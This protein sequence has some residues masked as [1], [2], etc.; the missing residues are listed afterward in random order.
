MLISRRV[1]LRSSPALLAAGPLAPLAVRAQG[2]PILIGG[3]ANDSGGSIFYA[4][5]L[6]MFEKAGLNVKVETLA[7]AGT[8]ASAV[9]GGSLTVSTLT[10]PGIAIA[11]E[12]G[13]PV[14]IIAPASIYNSANPTSGII[15]LKTSPI[16]KA[17]DLNGKTIATRDLS[18][19]SYYG[20][21]TWMDKNGGDSKTV[22]WV[23]I[24]DPATVPAMQSGRVDAASVSEPALDAAIHGP[25]A[26]MLAP[27]YDAIGSGFMIAAYFVT[28]EYART[29]VDIVRKISEV[30]I[31]AGIWANKN[32]PLSAKILEK[33][34][35]VPVPPGTTRVTYAER[36]R[37]A[38]A[39][40]VLDLLQGYGVLKGTMRASDMF[41]PQVPTS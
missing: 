14:T 24:P 36:M 32:R 34:S 25:D 1:W 37:P 40:P 12:K 31:N 5:D 10:I 23:E 2:A 13:I 30:I 22:K 9:V 26:R 38:D 19:M 3:T 41:A 8:A 11:R 35:G 27:V 18:N 4:Q 15:V 7:N 17:A 39:Q 16:R 29:H 6:G 20:A 33:Y 28:E 21:K